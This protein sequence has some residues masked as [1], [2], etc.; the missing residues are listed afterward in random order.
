[1]KQPVFKNKQYIK[2]RIYEHVSLKFN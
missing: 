2:G 1:M